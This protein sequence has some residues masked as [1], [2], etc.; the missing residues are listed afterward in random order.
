[1]F[2]FHTFRF[3][4]CRWT[5]CLSSELAFYHFQSNQC[6]KEVDLQTLCSQNLNLN[7]LTSCH[8]NSSGV[9]FQAVMVKAT[10]RGS[11]CPTEVLRDAPSQPR[12]RRTVTL[13]AFSSRGSPARQRACPAPP[14][15]ATARVTLAAASW[16]IGGGSLEHAAGTDFQ[17][18][19]FQPWR[20][21]RLV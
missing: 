14:P 10:W 21:L 13:T 8:S 2:H 3:L 7:Q 20:S 19:E 15:A 9:Q 18:K 16:H 5:L 17:V 6:S 1:M 11:M 12:G 4:L